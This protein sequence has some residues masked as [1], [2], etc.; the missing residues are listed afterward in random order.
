M[1]DITSDFNNYKDANHYGPWINSL[2]L[3]YMYEGVGLLDDGN[4]ETY[5]S[6]E[7][8]K[9]LQYDY[10]S[11]NGQEDYENDY[12]A[13]TLFTQ[14]TYDVEP[15][16]IDFCTDTV[17]IN[18]AEIIDEGIDGNAGLKCVGKISRDYHE[19]SLIREYIRDFEYIGVK[20]ENVDLSRYHYMIFYG[21]KVKDNGQPTV[22]V[23]D[24]EGNAVAECRIKYDLLDEEW[25][26][27]IIDLSELSGTGFIIFNGGYV[28]STGSKD[29]EYIFSNIVLY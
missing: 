10:P 25:H 27:Y 3:K 29:S 20:L 6:D 13:A 23:Y 22:Y 18:G 26:Q 16:V 17:S 19:G 15:V 11:L 7:L 2:I 12:Y 4:F 14:K 24:S 8:N 9:H 5:L 1:F 28:D 21:K